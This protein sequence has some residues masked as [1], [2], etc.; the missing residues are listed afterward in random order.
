M[1][2]STQICKR[3]YV[4]DGEN[5][6]WEIDFPFL[7][8]QDI[9]VYVT[10]PDGTQTQ[11]TT[12]YEIQLENLCVIYPTLASGQAPL[13]QGY[14]LTLL[15]K[16]PLTQEISLT[17]QGVLDAKELENG[18]DK[19][20]LQLQEA[21]EQL[22]RSIQYPVSSNHTTTDAQ[23]FLTQLKEEQTTALTQTLEDV[24]ST[25]QGLVA[26]IQT[27][28][29]ARSQAD[30]ALQQSVQALTGIVSQNNTTSS[31]R[32]TALEENMVQK[33]NTL[34]NSQLEAL[35]SG[36]T[37]QTVAQVQANKE[38]IAALDE[39]LDENRPW[40]KPADWIDIRSGALSN[41]VYFLV[42]HSADYSQYPDFF[43]NATISNSG[44]YDVFV[45]GI[46]QATTASATA[47]TLNWQTLA[48]ETGF[49]V[50]TP[51]SLRAHIVRVTPSVS[52]NTIT[53]LTCDG[54]Y[55]SPANRTGLL[56]AHFTITNEFNADALFG[57]N[58]GSASVM[59][60]AVTSSNGVLIVSTLRASFYGCQGLVEVPTFSSQLNSSNLNCWGTFYNCKKL[61]KVVFDNIVTAT[62]GNSNNMFVLCEELESIEGIKAF[63]L[64]NTSFDSCYNLKKLPVLSTVST[65]ANAAVILNKNKKLGPFFNIQKRLF[66]SGGNSNYFIEGLKGLIVSNEAPFDGTS[67]QID[68]SYTGLDRQALVNLFK[69]MPTVSASQ[70]CNIT[71]TTGANALTAE[72]LA[73][74]TDKGWSVVR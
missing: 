42:G 21:Q 59:L 32:I 8:T 65:Y 22:S 49:D 60:Q 28:S 20:T 34:S 25:R 23:A 63:I 58:G 30:I 46:K 31:A 66:A 19:L 12:G 71:G 1:T 70:V 38:N 13:A 44:T 68:V 41:S 52:T 27:E 69:S 72:D 3:I 4:A 39:E 29:T 54:S 2:I 48:L 57:N 53:K 73:I 74:A 62:N 56:W 55:T 37:S 9:S 5:R 6:Q 35:N 47:T 61:K 67:P 26:Q 15:R 16:T 10:S 17:Q 36:V 14:T 33:Q 50:T 40:K 11:V 51:T 18:Y 43:V 24:E 7:S 45:D 64:G